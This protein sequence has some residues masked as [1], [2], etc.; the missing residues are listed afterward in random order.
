MNRR[1]TVGPFRIIT[2][3]TVNIREPTVWRSSAFIHYGNKSEALEWLIDA[4]RGGTRL[5]AQEAAL[6]AGLTLARTLGPDDSV[7]NRLKKI[8]LSR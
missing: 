3:E 1:D 2:V 8:G 6:A 7:A 5:G 4:G